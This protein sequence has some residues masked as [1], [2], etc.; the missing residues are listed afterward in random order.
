MVGID[1]SRP[2][3]PVNIAILTISDSRT[4]ETDKSGQILVERL[5]AAGH[6]LL[7][8]RL[9]PDERETIVAVLWEWVKTSPGGCGDYDGGDGNY[10]SRCDPGGVGGGLRE[11]DSRLW[12]TVPPH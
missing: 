6:Q 3:L 10:R 12:G 9:V 7:E 11:G 8:R 1:E 4:L 2:F 5:Q